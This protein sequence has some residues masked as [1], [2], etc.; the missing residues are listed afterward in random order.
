MA[1]LKENAL[2]KVL[3]LGE[4]YI[5]KSCMIEVFRLNKFPRTH[6]PKVV[7]NFKKTLKIDD[8]AIDLVIWDYTRQKEYEPFHAL[9]FCNVDIIIICF[10]IENHESFDLIKAIWIKEINKFL[11]Q[12]VVGLVGLKSDLRKRQDECML[13][14]PKDIE[15]LA[16]ELNAKFYFECSA[17][18]NKNV[19]EIFQ[20]TCRLFLSTQGQV[21]KKKKWFCK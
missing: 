10:S 15:N 11:P 21:S 3:V 8:K 5:G 4:D 2:K 9:A 14:Q 18:E 13:I 7:E 6:V 12:T 1:K 17:I 20:E 19:H 16:K